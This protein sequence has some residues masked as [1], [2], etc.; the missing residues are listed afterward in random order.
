MKWRAERD[1]FAIVE[2]S[3]PAARRLLN[4]LPPI[5]PATAP[6]R[7]AATA[8]G[9]CQRVKLYAAGDDPLYPGYL[10]STVPRM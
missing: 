9:T 1:F 3:N 6:A 8:D 10:L 4:P 5:P 2:K 7:G